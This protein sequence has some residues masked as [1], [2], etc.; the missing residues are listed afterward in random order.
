LY[1]TDRLPKPDYSSEAKLKREIEEKYKRRT[2]EGSNPNLP[3][4]KQERS[5]SHMNKGKK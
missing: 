5:D 3:D 4:I 1:L 2:Y